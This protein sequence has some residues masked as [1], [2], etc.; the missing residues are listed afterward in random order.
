MIRYVI[1]LLAMAAVIAAPMI[2]RPAASVRTEDYAEKDRLVIIT[3]H[4]ETL[5]YELERSFA[6]W[7][8]EK[9]G[10]RVVIDWRVPGGTSDIIKIV[11]SEFIAAKELGPNRGIGLDLML[12]GGPID[13]LGLKK[14]GHIVATDASGKYGPAAV[15]AAHPD[16]FTDAAI[17]VTLS[18]QE[19]YDPGMVWIG[20]C[21]SS[22][23]ICWNKENLERRGLKSPA[24]WADLASPDYENQLAISDPTK[25]G[26][27]TAMFECILQMS[28][29]AAVKYAEQKPVA[30][31]SGEAQLSP[32]GQA[33]LR[34]RLAGFESVLGEPAAWTSLSADPAAFGWAEGFRMI[35]Y[36]GANTR[37]WT[38]SST[39][40]PLDVSEGEALAGMCVD[41]YGRNVI[42]RLSHANG[43]SRLG[44][45]APPGGTTIS[46][47]PVAMF[48]GASNPELATRFIEFIIS[49]E[50]QKLWGLKAGAP[51][52]PEK[53]ALRNMPIRRDYYVEANLAHAADPELRP[54][55]PGMAFQYEAKY[56]AELFSGIRFLIRAMC[57]D[58]H[59]ELKE[60]WH[61]LIA[62][63]FP[64]EATAVFDSLPPEL[65]YDA[66]KKHIAPVL[67][68]KD[69][70]ATARL[71]RELS[72][73][74]RLS[75][76][77][78]RDL[79]RAGR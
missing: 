56:T 53:M 72:E 40:I 55:D 61:E 64:P 10:R 50:G 9:H 31:A 49:P 73:I 11:N 48:R 24:T 58:P 13:Y 29:A 17:P 69:P 20:T 2:L 46:P 42:E 12:G 45:I 51:G 21:L 30:G 66:V 6:R 39:K 62:H 16:W 52:G 63:G 41:F 8:Q 26:T 25:S 19:L 47:Q 33:L 27:V 70:V 1:I 65:S 15:K 35:R 54:L 57:I 34:E 18:G 74:F 36:I 28:M 38:D 59:H 77:K 37:Y 60:A 5:R 67:K 78:A 22:F 4:V 7:M 75:Y 23:G 32:E 68:A 79:A 3:P 76:L 43:S 44:F 14:S 71:A